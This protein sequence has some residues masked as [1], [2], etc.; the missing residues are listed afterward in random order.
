MLIE[1]VNWPYGRGGEERERRGG[2]REGRGG[3]R[4]MKLKLETVT[5]C[6]SVILLGKSKQRLLVLATWPQSLPSDS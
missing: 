1:L 4:R 6:V 5:P 2:S 3:K